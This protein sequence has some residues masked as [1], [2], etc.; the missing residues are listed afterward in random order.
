VP[1]A[2]PDGIGPVA[3]V[4]SGLLDDHALHH[5]CQA[6]GILRLAEKYGGLRLEAACQRALA[7]GDPA[8]RTVKTILERGLEG[9][10]EASALPLLPAGAFLLGPQELLAQME[11]G[12]DTQRAGVG[13]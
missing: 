6:Q 7:F 1:V 5:L 9:Q 12:V 3:T 8:Y 2:G 11:I 13:S 10:E 4:V